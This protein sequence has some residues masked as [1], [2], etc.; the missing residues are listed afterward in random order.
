MQFHVKYLHVCF[1]QSLAHLNS[2]R[3]KYK[4]FNNNIDNLV[5]IIIIILPFHSGFRKQCLKISLNSSPHLYASIGKTVKDI[6][7]CSKNIPFPP[8]QMIRMLNFFLLQQNFSY[9]MA[10]TSTIYE[11]YGQKCMITYLLN[12]YLKTMPRFPIFL[13]EDLTFLCIYYIRQY[14]KN[15]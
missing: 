14:L 4:H 6:Q 8:A 3:L 7:Y 1:I 5:F 9:S 10:S 11:T 2:K 13:I 15:F 12:F